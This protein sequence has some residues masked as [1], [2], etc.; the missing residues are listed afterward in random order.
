M[1]LILYSINRIIMHT[2]VF[3]VAMHEHSTSET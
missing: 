1:K 3:T 2:Q